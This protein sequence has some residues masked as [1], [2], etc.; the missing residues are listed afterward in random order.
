MMAVTGQMARR[1]LRDQ[2][3]R[4]ERVNRH[5]GG[6]SSVLVWTEDELCEGVRSAESPLILVLDCIQDPHNLGACMRSADAAGVL[7][8]VAP[9]DKSASLT[10]AACQVAC[11]A[12]QHTPFVQVTNLS[13]C[14]SRLKELGIWL[15][16]TADEAPQTLYECDLKGPLGV[17][18]GAEGSGMRRL[19]REH[20]DF[21]VSIPMAVGCRVECLNVSV[22]TGV[23]LFEARRQRTV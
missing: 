12:T 7:A 2:V 11:G 4:K 6:D 14:L 18:M 8:V 19:T 13:R 20:C 1:V 23:T 3:E 21:L 10:V 17:V 22:A 16:G 15:V 5:A 9:K